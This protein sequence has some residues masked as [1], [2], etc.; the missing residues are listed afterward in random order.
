MGVNNR[1]MRERVLRN[2]RSLGRNICLCKK[3]SAKKIGA[4]G[5]TYF[6]SILEYAII[7]LVDTL[8]KRGTTSGT[9]KEPRGTII[10]EA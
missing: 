9:I 7:T 1:L 10:V 6:I 8:Y 4:N 3:L 2:I 5:I